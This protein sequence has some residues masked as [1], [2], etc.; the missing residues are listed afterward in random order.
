V[1]IIL[2]QISQNPPNPGTFLSKKR[3]QLQIVSVSIWIEGL[4]R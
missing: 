4:A 1:H 2:A 3:K